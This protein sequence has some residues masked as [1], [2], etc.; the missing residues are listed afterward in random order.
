MEVLARGFLG[1]LRPPLRTQH[2]VGVLM[3]D[4]IGLERLHG[5][6]YGSANHARTHELQQCKFK[7]VV[8]YYTQ[9]PGFSQ[10]V[11]VSLPLTPRLHL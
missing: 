5:G 9:G 4:V 7:E 8:H 1:L 2:K 10:E 3:D 11:E 6:H